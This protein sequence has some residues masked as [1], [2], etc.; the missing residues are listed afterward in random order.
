MEKCKSCNLDT[1]KSSRSS[2]C[3]NYRKKNSSIFTNIKKGYEEKQYCYK[4]GFRKLCKDKRIYDTINNLSKEMTKVCIE[5]SRFL[6]LHYIRLLDNKKTI[7]ALK[8]SLMDKI[9][10]SFTEE[11]IYIKYFKDNEELIKSF[12]LYLSLRPEELGYYNIKQYTNHTHIFESFRV[13]YLTNCSNH[14]TTN[15]KRWLLKYI[16]I[17]FKISEYS[18]IWKRL[19][20]YNKGKI[21]HSIYGYLC[22]DNDIGNFKITDFDQKCQKNKLSKDDIDNINDY[23]VSIFDDIINLGIDF[24]EKI[25]F[26]KDK[27]FYNYY[28]VLY[29]LNK[30]FIAN[31]QKQLSLFPIYNYHRKYILID[32][33]TFYHLVKPFYKDFP[34]KETDLSHNLELLKYW[35]FKIFNIKRRKKVFS[36][37]IKTNGIGTS[38]SIKKIVKKK[39]DEDEKIIT[40]YIPDNIKTNYNNREIHAIDPGSVN[41]FTCLS[42]NKY[43][44]PKELLDNNMGEIKQWQS[45]KFYKYKGNE[46]SRKN[47]NKILRENNLLNKLKN[48]PSIRF[49]DLDSVKKHIKYTLDI[50]PNI[51]KAYNNSNIDYNKWQNYIRTQKTYD[52]ISDIITKGNKDSIIFFGAANFS[53]NTKGKLPSNYRKVK[54]S[55][56][57]RG[58]KVI[59]I[60]EY[61]TSQKCSKCLEHIPKTNKHMGFQKCFNTLN[62]GKTWSRDINSA[63]NIMY[64]GLNLLINGKR[65]E[66]FSRGIK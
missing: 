56:E 31:D 42:I 6:Q 46:H 4:T 15:I 24:E 27:E 28:E 10:K 1:H 26:E 29:N 63:R 57:K 49:S 58:N 22:F 12:E 21:K 8:P 52:F 33:R 9:F 11:N 62:C 45:S 2:K 18:N 3:L 64:I 59:Y 20:S 55:L 16:D 40:D 36:F 32:T 38:I 44:S 50:L 65:P 66:I 19:S 41:P 5:A 14:I 54:E 53:T 13:E 61:Y 7:P 60:D 47:T 34:K 23:S 35:W 51:L 17:K 25:N 43:V 37:S 39:T 30:F 48:T